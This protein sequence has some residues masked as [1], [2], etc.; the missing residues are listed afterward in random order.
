MNKQTRRCWAIRSDKNNMKVLFGE[1]SKGRFRQGWGY[2]PTQDLQLL[3]T[4]IDKGG[5]WWE[6]LSA[7]QQEALPHLRMLA[8]SNDS[9]KQGDILVIPNLPDYGFFC[10]AEVTGEYN[11]APM[12][13]KSDFDVNDSTF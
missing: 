11:Y 3:Q 9:I 7:V 12:R 4:E 8:R 1:L 10:L 13:L 6:R 2:D 5:S